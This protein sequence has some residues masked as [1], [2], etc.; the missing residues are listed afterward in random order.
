MLKILDKMSD[1]E[2][3]SDDAD[4]TKSEIHKPH[5]INGSTTLDPASVET[6][7]RLPCRKSMSAR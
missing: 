7:L 3:V 2:K 6:S 1:E 5:D 4:T